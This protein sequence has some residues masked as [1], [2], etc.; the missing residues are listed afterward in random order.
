MIKE[1]LVEKFKEVHQLIESEEDTINA[2]T[3]VGTPPKNNGEASGA[4]MISS[5]DINSNRVVLL[6][7]LIKLYDGDYEQIEAQI[8]EFKLA[9]QALKTAVFIGKNGSLSLKY[10]TTYRIK[11]WLDVRKKLLKRDVPLLMMSVY[12]KNGQLVARTAYS[13]LDNMLKNWEVLSDE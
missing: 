5:G 10:G 11:T 4:G 1:V 6:T 9:N 12:D 8:N 13:S 3:I 2:V 7:G